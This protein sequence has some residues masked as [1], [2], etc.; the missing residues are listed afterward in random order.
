MPLIHLQNHT[1]LTGK[2]YGSEPFVMCFLLTHVKMGVSFF[3]EATRFGWFWKDTTRKTTLGVPK[4]RHTQ[5]ITQV[6]QMDLFQP[7]IR[8][9]KV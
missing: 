9:D 5:M 8:S 4:E 6:A 1:F 7:S 2:R 3:L